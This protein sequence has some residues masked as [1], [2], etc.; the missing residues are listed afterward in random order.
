MQ[1]IPII[2]PE[3]LREKLEK[4]EKLNL[5]DVREE[6]EVQEGMIPEAK[7]IPMGEIPNSLDQLDKQKEYIFICRS[8][9]RSENVCHYLQEQ[10][11][12]VRNMI[13]GM[14]E[15]TGKVQPKK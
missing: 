12:K 8:G 2:T 6:E 14:L 4:G 10:G 15:W 1:E 9:R 3:E 7:H 13:G 5:I 11:Y